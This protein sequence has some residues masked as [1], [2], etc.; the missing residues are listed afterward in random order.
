[1]SSLRREVLNSFKC[2]HKARKKVFKDDHLALSAARKRINEEYSANKHV[3]DEV[4]IKELVKYAMEVQ[5]E[6]L[7]SVIQAKRVAPDRYEVRITEETTKLDNFP[8]KE[9]SEP[10]K[11]SK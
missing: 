11:K 4:A 6:L 8:F 9:C 2:L 1:M 3:K 10:K 7:T 5:M